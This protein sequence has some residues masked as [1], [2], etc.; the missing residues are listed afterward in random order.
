MTNIADILAKGESVQVEFKTSTG[1]LERA[2]ETLCAFLNGEGGTVLF[3]VTDA[4]VAVGQEVSDKTKRDIAEALNHFYPMI[5]LPVEYIDVAGGKQVIAITASSY[6][7]S[8]PFTYRNRPY[9]RVESTTSVMPQ[10]MYQDR[11]INRDDVSVRWEK[12]LDYSLKIEDLDEND[13]KYAM[14]EAVAS[15][16]VQK[17]Y[18]VSEV[19]LIL[20]R[21]ELRRDGVLTHAAA[22]L[23]LKGSSMDYPQCTLRL[24]RFLGKDKRTFID[25]RE[26]RGN[27]F[28]QF[29]AAMEFFFKHLP[30]SG[31]IRGMYREERLLVPYYA[32]RE[33]VINALV[34]RSYRLS[35]GSIGIAIYEDRIE[36]ENAGSLPNHWT[37]EDFWN[38]KLSY[39]RNPIIAQTLYKCNMLEK[40]GR[41]VSLILDECKRSHIEQPTIQDCKGAVVLTFRYPYNMTLTEAMTGAWAK[42]QTQTTQDD[43]S[44]TSTTD[45]MVDKVVIK[46]LLSD[47]LSDKAALVSDKLSDK[48]TEILS[49]LYQKEFISVGDICDLLSVSLPTSRRYLAH[50][51]AL[52][53]LESHGANK[54]RTYT[55]VDEGKK[56][57]GFKEF[58]QE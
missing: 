42:A 46:H 53:L 31:V 37:A 14:S 26:V 24:A 9:R 50:L 21:L 3:G 22:V 18:A 44:S 12:L 35:F 52:G 39:P 25:S 34:H 23:F 58:E 56:L 11:L 17:E 51:T 2:M 48:Y 49:L 13:I 7:P 16:R 36:I 20:D 8:A 38:N 4:G 6:H 54:N 1:Q 55:L 40:W 41:G 28:K 43:R 33:A 57:Y 10:G 19:D 5:E 15:G 29:T 32:L 27:V 30:Q 47:K 45:K